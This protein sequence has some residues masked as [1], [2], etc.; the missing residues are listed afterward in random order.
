MSG[1]KARHA[2]ALALTAWYLMLPPSIPYSHEVNQSSPLSQWIIGRTFHRNEGCEAAKA[3]LRI[4][5]LAAQTEIDAYARRSQRN[6]ESRCI[7]CRAQC[8]SEDDQ[9]L[10]EKQRQ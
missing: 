10:G 1:M 4:E 7:A 8:V 6:P 2:T 3:H 5:A 9:R